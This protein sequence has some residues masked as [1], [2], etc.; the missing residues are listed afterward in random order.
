MPLGDR[1]KFS[2]FEINDR[3]SAFDAK[4]VGTVQCGANA[5]FAEGAN[6]K[7]IET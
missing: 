5:D 2:C 7:F 3:H 1:V 4:L 6:V